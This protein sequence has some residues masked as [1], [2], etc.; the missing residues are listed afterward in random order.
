MSSTSQTSYK[1]TRLRIVNSKNSMDEGEK[2]KRRSKIIEKAKLSV[3]SYDTT[4]VAMVPSKESK[5]KPMFPK[6]LEWIMD[7][8][9]CDG[10]WCH[11]P[12]HP[13]LVK[14]YLSST[15]ASILALHKWKLGPSLIKRGLEFIEANYW[16]AVDERQLTPIGFDIIF[17]AMIELAIEYGLELPFHHEILNVLLEKR[18]NEIARCELE[19]D[20]SHLAYLIEGLGKKCKW[21]EISIHQR[22]NGSFFNS[23]SATAAALFHNHNQQCYDYLTSLFKNF[24]RAAP[25]IYP[26][27]IYSQLR[28]VDNLQKLGIDDRYFKTEIDTI[29]DNIYG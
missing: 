21:K 19:G 25:T 15:L 26:L 20:T 8:Q 4:W 11:H 16:A 7:N 22:S 17:P 13:L 3:S 9:Q 6:C 23:P 28:A 5:Q 1:L 27:E 18:E 24:N 29:L 12:Y 2:R 10:S 14:D